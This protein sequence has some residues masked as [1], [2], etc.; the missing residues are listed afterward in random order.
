M[1]PHVC[2]FLLVLSPHK[3][4]KRL[5]L[6]PVRRIDLIPWSATFKD[7]CCKSV[8]TSL[9]VP[10]NPNCVPLTLFTTTRLQTNQLLMNPFA[11]VTCASDCCPAWATWCWTRSTRE[12][13]SLTFCSPLWR[14]CSASETT[15]RSSW[16]VPRSMRR[17]FPSI[18]VRWPPKVTEPPGS[19]WFHRSTLCFINRQVSNDP[20]S[21]FDLPRGGIPPR[22]CRGVN[23]VEPEGRNTHKRTLSPEPISNNLSFKVPTSE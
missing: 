2:F 19:S 3:M 5:P 1:R 21:W 10:T 9:F 17:S 20:H 13:C 23:Q 7:H 15:S 6:N 4:A 14:I 11:L 12:T 8:P 16:W 22:G 18:L